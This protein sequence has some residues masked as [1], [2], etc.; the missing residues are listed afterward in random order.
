[1]N[2]WEKG[3][4]FFSCLLDGMI[5]PVMSLIY[6]EHGASIENLAIFITIYSVTVI[7]LE[8]PSGMMADMLGRKKIFI[9]SHIALMV[10]YITTLYANS[11]MP[12]VLANLFHGV[13]RAFGSGSLEALLIDKTIEKQ[14]ED[15]LKGINRQLIVLN[16][17]ALA[18]GAIGGGIL[19][20][21]G[22]RYSVLLICIIVMEIVLLIISGIMIK[23][24]WDRQTD[25]SLNENFVNQLK[26]I[27]KVLKT[28]DLIRIM[29][30]MSI[31]LAMNLTLV[32]VYWQQKLLYILPDNMGWFFGVV[33]CL[34]YVGL[35]LGSKIGE[36]ISEK[37]EVEKVFWVF[38]VLLPCVIICLGQSFS[39][40]M[41]LAM[42]IMTYVVWGIG[43][44]Q[45]GTIFHRH[46]ES[47]Y[48][49]SMLSVKS[50]FVKGGCT[51]TSLFS[52]VI[53]HL[54]GL[55]YVWIVIPVITLLMTCVCCNVRYNA[56][57][58]ASPAG[59]G[60]TFAGR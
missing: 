30:F 17:I 13:G 59:K 31:T 19:G 4:F 10:Y 5:V 39:W 26:L 2:I 58:K 25:R 38:R 16:S 3:I 35:S 48:R 50:L 53:I 51:V 52:S 37:R 55:S 44:L 54:A 49:A 27:G 41:F 56:R 6:L 8:V 32:E 12:L 33:S 24:K 21:V 40:W 14:G 22:T 18:A 1:M 42:Y 29:L 36:Y 11:A 28:S 23:E 9:L 15:N 60:E 47:E 43:D 34:G 7:V 57:K 20:T 45:E 46:V